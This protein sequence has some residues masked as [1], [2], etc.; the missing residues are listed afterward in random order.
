MYLSF[1]FLRLIVFAVGT[2]GLDI[3]YS[4]YSVV[5]ALA[6]KRRLRVVGVADAVSLARKPFCLVPILSFHQILFYV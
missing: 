2:V 3:D 4:L 1:T 6:R 5:V